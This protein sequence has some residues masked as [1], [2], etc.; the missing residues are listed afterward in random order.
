MEKENQVE[1]TE[2]KSQEVANIIELIKQFLPL[3]DEKYLETLSQ[4][5]IDRGDRMDSTAA[6]DRSYHPKRA[7]LWREQ[8]RALQHLRGFKN[9]LIKCQE[10]KDEIATLVRILN[11]INNSF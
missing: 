5:M 9:S 8:G 3:L 2:A 10:L 11:G 1:L 6:L 7:E 4:Q